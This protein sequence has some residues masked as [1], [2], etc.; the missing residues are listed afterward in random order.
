MFHFSSFSVAYFICVIS[1]TGVPTWTIFVS[2]LYLPCRVSDLLIQQFVTDVISHFGFDRP[3]CYSISIFPAIFVYFL[4]QISL[5]VFFC[6]VDDPSECF[7]VFSMCDVVIFVH[8]CVSSI[9]SFDL[10]TF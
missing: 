1:W 4:I 8:L 6:L 2:G 3:R 10:K 9:L 7:L 5:A